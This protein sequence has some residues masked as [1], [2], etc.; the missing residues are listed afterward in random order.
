MIKIKLKIK[1]YYCNRCDSL[2]KKETDPELRKEYTFYCPDCDENMYKFEVY[3][4]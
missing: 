1:E 2:V 4:Q 3:N